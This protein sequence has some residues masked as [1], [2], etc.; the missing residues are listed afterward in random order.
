M[1]ST[2]L[3]VVYTK[4]INEDSAVKIITTDE[5]AFDTLSNDKVAIKTLPGQVANVPVGD[6]E[7]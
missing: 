2:T 4:N 5:I 7:T 1:T 3:E 6:E